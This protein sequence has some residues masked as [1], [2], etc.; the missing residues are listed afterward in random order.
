MKRYQYRF[1]KKNST[2]H[3][4]LEIVDGICSELHRGHTPIAIFLDLSKAFDTLGHKTLLY[5]LKHVL[6]IL[7]GLNFFVYGKQM[8][9]PCGMFVCLLI[10]LLVFFI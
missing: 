7:S 5:K 6:L 10:F 3:A 9:L 1:R 4:V 8:G 2:E